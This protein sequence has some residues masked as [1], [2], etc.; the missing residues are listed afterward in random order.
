MSPETTTVQVPPVLY[1]IARALLQKAL[2][3]AAT[4]ATGYVA[5]TPGDKDA[6]IHAGVAAGLWA[7]SFGWTWVQEHSAHAKILEALMSPPPGQP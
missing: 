6:V 5:L 7:L 4:A 3:A 2:T 1:S